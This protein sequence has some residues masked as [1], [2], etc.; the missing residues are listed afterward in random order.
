MKKKGTEK[1]NDG[2]KNMPKQ[3]YIYGAVLGVNCSSIVYIFTE[4]SKV[5]TAV[6]APNWRPDISQLPYTLYLTKSLESLYH[7]IKSYDLIEGSCSL[8]F[9][10]DDEKKAE[11]KAVSEIIK[12][13]GSYQSGTRSASNVQ[14][15]IIAGTEVGE[16]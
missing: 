11:M 3:L 2:L 9:K 5:V 4:L 1:N 13:V 16:M 15:E 12:K 10:L 8:Y 7:C 6:A 14:Q